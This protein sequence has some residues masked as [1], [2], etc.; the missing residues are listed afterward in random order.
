MT[1][2]IKINGK[3]GV[4]IMNT[5]SIEIHDYFVDK[6]F[7]LPNREQVIALN[8][9]DLNTFL[10]ISSKHFESEYRKFSPCSTEAAILDFVVFEFE[11]AMYN[12]TEFKYD[13]NN[14]GKTDTQY[15]IA[16]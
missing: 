11:R 13:I 14:C 7:L 1:H 5:D 16:V 3:N 15:V 9:A 8:M 4:E 6:M 2:V 12:A 10:E